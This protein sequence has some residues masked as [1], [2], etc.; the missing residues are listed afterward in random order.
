[1]RLDSEL[2]KAILNNIPDQAWLKDK[3]SHYILVNDAFMAACGL[4]E[5]EILRRSPADVW[6]GDWGRQYERTDLEV[7]RSGAR[8]RYEEIRCG[9]DGVL[10]WFDTIKTPIRDASGAVVGTAGIS[11]D[12]TDRK[13]SE[14]ALARLNRLYAMRSKTNQVIAQIADATQLLYRF[15]RIAVQA[16]G[17]RLACVH[18]FEGGQ[19]SRASFAA[20][21]ALRERFDASA[22]ALAWRGDAHRVYVCRDIARATRCKPQARA[23][24]ALGMTG[25][26]A[27]PLTRGGRTVAVCLLFAKDP[28]LFSADVVRLLRAL[29][30]DLS[31][32]LD[33]LGEAEMRR[34]AEDDLRA[35]RGQLRELSAYLQSV[36]EEERTRIARELHDE[37]GQSL[38]A[39]RLGLSVIETQ[40]ARG[41]D[42]WR[43]ELQG[44]KDIADNTVDAV[45]RLATD[46]RPALLD[47]LGLGPAIEWLAESLGERSALQCDVTLPTEPVEIGA[48]L[49]TGVFR[50]V[51]EALTNVARHGQASR[52]A[53]SLHVTRRTLH[54][55]IEDNGRGMENAPSCGRK[56]LGL[57]GMRERALMLG[58]RLTVT[59]AP[60]AGTRVAAEL[61]FAAGEGD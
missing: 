23:A 46:L 30:S 13:R 19:A 27:L 39:L 29:S 59:S 41:N 14:Q 49:S 35:S 26:A 52:V 56:R 7:V 45:Q 53:V 17:F 28:E 1:M 58:G 32:A 34:Q 12:I 21:A 51:Q 61:P 3:D 8:A 42:D 4:R 18:R 2:H 20:S 60:G 50:I 44:L 36:R 43:R 15:C 9:H 57:L 22:G 11:R 25:F 37:L 38:T 54:L 48:A 47:E 5:P 16:G 6:A 10:R 40:A 55:S 33:A 24:Q 31:F